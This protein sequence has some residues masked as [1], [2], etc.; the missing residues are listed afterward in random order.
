MT[1]YYKVADHLFSMTLPDNLGLWDKLDNY[2]PF[3]T[4]E[5]EALFSIELVDRFFLPEGSQPAYVVPGQPGEPRVDLYKCGEDWCFEMSPVTECPVSARLY[6]YKGFKRGRLCCAKGDRNR[7]FAI[8]NAAMLMFAFSTVGLGTLEMHAS[9]TVN[10]GLAY[11]FLAKSGTGKSTHSRMWL[12]NIPGSY[13]LNDDNPV[14]RTY[15]DGRVLAYGTPWSG[16]TPC[17]KNEVVPVGAFV[18]IR[19]SEENKL[20]RRDVLESYADIYSSSSGFKS[21]HEMAGGLHSTIEKV[22]LNKPCYVMDCRPDADAAK[23]CH[24]GLTGRAE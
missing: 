20:T 16:K 1:K 2:A 14:V 19:R 21:D 7:I 6:A 10:D 22:V 3:E 18:K 23:V 8:N 9:V 11:L 12:E 24:S 5:G 15:D 13:L 17:Y 4:D